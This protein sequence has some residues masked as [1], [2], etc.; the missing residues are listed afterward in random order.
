MLGL[1]RCSMFDLLLLH[2]VRAVHRQVV[3][4]VACT[5]VKL[6]G[7]RCCL[8]PSSNWL[9]PIILGICV[10][11]STLHL[12]CGAET[13]MWRSESADG[14]LVRLATSVGVIAS[15]PPRESYTHA[16]VLVRSYTVHKASSCGST[17]YFPLTT[18]ALLDGCGI[19]E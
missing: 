12:F 7:T 13:Y 1:W 3:F 11:D 18:H 17:E 15:I 6:Y 4:C 2:R 10:Y 9:V 19:A 5:L 8:K 14:Y 16:C